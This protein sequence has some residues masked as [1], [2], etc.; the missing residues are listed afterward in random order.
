MLAD[1]EVGD[2]YQLWAQAGS[3]F[4]DYVEQPVAVPREG[5]ALPIVLEPAQTASLSGRMTDALGNSIPWLGLWL[6]GGDSAAAF[7]MINGDAEGFFQVEELQAGELRLQTYTSPYLTVSGIRLGAG[8]AGYIELT[9][10]SGNLVLDGQV[11]DVRGAPIPGAEVSLSWS[12]Q[13]GPLSSRSSRQATSGADGGFR[14]SGLGPGIHALSVQAPGFEGRW[15]EHDPLN[16]GA[17]VLVELI[18]K[19]L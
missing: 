16:D 9:L 10:D 1:V 15:L 4:S 18:E 11:T 19:T 3:P 8:E 14:C 2:D 7:G 17:H 12:L 6:R 13:E 5:L